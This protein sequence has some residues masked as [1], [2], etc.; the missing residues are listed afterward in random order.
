ME[1]GTGTPV[2]VS[3]T[4]TIWANRHIDVGT[5]TYDPKLNTLSITLR[6][7]WSLRDISEPV[8]IQGYNEIPSKTPDTG[9]LKSYRGKETNIEVPP[10]L[11]YVIHLDVQLC[12]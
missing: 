2:P 9:L 8:K 1:N 3:S 4:E 5:V 12:I 11:Y 7:G 6:K 10:H